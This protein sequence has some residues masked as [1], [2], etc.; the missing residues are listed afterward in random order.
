MRHL[1]RG[2]LA[3]VQERVERVLKLGPDPKLASVAREILAEAH[4]R[5]AMASADPN[6]RL[7]HLDTALQQTP[8]AAKLHFHR[9]LTLWQNGHLAEA[10]IELDATATREPGRRGLAYLRALARIATEQSWDSAGLTAAEANTLRLVHRL[11]QRKPLTGS[12]MIEEPLLG[13]GAGLWQALVAM[14]QNPTAAP[15]DQLKVAAEQNTRKPVGRILTY[16]QGVAA[17]RAGDR[18]TAFT[19]WSHAHSAGWVS[20][21]LAENLTALLR[22]DVI[23][24]AQENHWQD[25]INRLPDPG[26]DRIV[27]E[28]A[29]LA[30]FHLGY[31]AA[32]AGQWPLAAQHWRK[33][34]EL[35]PNRYLSQN[36]ALA[37]EASENW[38]NAAE[39]WRDMV[40]RRPRK[41]DHPDYLTDVQVAALWSHAAECYGHTN[42]T[43]EIEPC[44]RNALKYAAGDTA[45]R[46]R[47]ADF[48]L[49]DERGD[50]AEVQLREITAADPQHV[51]A[52]VRLGRLY[53]GWW[54]RDP[55]PIWQQVL[56]VNPTHLEAREALVDDYIK[57]VNDQ[58]PFSASRFSVKHPGKSRVE[59]LEIGLGELPNHP[60]LLM[61]LGA[62]HAR[63]QHTQQARE[64]LLQAYQIAPQDVAVVNFVMHELLHVGGGDAV[65]QMIPVVRQIPRLLPVFWFDQAKMALQCKLGEQWA[66]IFFQ[67]AVK[68]SADPGLDDSRAGLLV[69]AYEVAHQENAS[70]LCAVLE[71]RIREEVPASGALSYIEAY[72]LH[73][74]KGDVHGAARLMR[75]AIKTARRVNDRGILRRA[76]TIESLLK[77]MPHRFDWQRVMKDLLPPDFM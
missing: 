35:N 26:A 22:E 49:R 77:G 76:E 4:F 27:A 50:A 65:E 3:L 32:Q 51:E 47:L 30:Y 7:G 10:L 42:L 43:D 58:A 17:L 20:P 48:L 66:D 6:K 44:L 40:R 59:T 74:E 16:Y 61:V 5:A 46:L 57:M 45:L 67:E 36:L 68:Y 71:K 2:D 31:E 56:A 70:G 25:M 12:V 41:E 62:T 23:G 18:D 60:K 69:E 38:V 37:E 21:E 39:A 72:R 64:Y 8:A 11:A 9:G 54:D 63:Q 34:N 29:S 52:L 33:A 19:A 15:L 13:K 75:E 14:R 73:F 28:T 53:E 1:R 55:M 24:L